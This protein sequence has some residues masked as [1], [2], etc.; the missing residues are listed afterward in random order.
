VVAPR[1]PHIVPLATYNW[2]DRNE[3]AAASE[4]CHYD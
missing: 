1:S 3:D 2:G 4:E